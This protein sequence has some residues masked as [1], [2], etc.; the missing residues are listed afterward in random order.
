MP[1]TADSEKS[2]AASDWSAIQVRSFP[3]IS[4]LLAETLPSHSQ[5]APFQ[6]QRQPC[7][8]Y[9]L[10]LL[11][12]QLWN[13]SCNFRQCLL[14]QRLSCLPLSQLAIAFSLACDACSAADGQRPRAM[15]WRLVRQRLI[16][17]GVPVQREWGAQR[18]TRVD[19]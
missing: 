11:S 7:P 8:F 14:V 5:L 16:L 18:S 4:C 3:L 10:L 6:L 9:P 17:I 19:Q 15:T 12:K 2:A 13:V 1:S